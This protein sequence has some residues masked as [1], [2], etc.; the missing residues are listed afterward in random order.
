MLGEFEKRAGSLYFSL[1]KRIFPWIIALSG[2]L[3]LPSG[4]AEPPASSACSSLHACTAQKLKWTGGRWSR[5]WLKRAEIHGLCRGSAD[6]SLVTELEKDLGF[7]LEVLGGSPTAETAVE[8]E[9]YVL[10][11]VFTYKLT[12]TVANLSVPLGQ[13]SFSFDYRAPSP[14]DTVI[15]I[16]CEQ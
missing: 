4:A 16:S 10:L 11:G 13:T 5:V 8:K 12:H 2:C 7:Q 6:K 15:R 9:P 1:V 3:S 14:R